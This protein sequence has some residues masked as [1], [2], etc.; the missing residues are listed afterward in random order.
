MLKTRVWKKEW[1]AIES[2]EFRLCSDARL[3]RSSSL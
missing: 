3:S 1:K 2:S